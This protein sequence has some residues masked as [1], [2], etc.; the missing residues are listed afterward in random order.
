[1][2]MTNIMITKL[3]NRRVRLGHCH[4]HHH[5]HHVHDDNQ[6][7]H[8]HQ[9]Y[10]GIQDHD[11]KTTKQESKPDPELSQRLADF[12]AHHPN[13]IKV[14]NHDDDDDDGD[15]DD[16]DGDDVV[17]EKGHIDDKI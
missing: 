1:M 8:H 6:Y 9:I 2:M 15:E 12:L 3:P 13:I 5:H 16:D 7:H 11:D 10:D 14:F 4:Q 17:G